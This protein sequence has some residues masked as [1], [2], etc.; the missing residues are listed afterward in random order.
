[1]TRGPDLFWLHVQGVYDIT[2]ETVLIAIKQ[3]K[4]HRHSAKLL[5]PTVPSVTL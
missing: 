3:Y 2:W 4:K 5:V 1:M